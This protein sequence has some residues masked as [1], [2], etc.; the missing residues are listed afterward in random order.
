[1]EINKIFILGKLT[2]DV[3]IRP[4]GSSQ[5]GVLNLLIEAYR[6]NK[7][8]DPF[9]E[10]CYIDVDTWGNAALKAAETLRAGD[11]I[12]VTG[13]LKSSSWQDKK[14][15]ETRTKHTIYCENYE[16]QDPTQL[17]DAFP[18]QQQPITIQANQPTV[19][20]RPNSVPANAQNPVNRPVT[21]PNIQRPVVTQPQVAQQRVAPQPVRQ[22]A[23]V[24]PPE[25]EESEYGE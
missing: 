13:R 15:G 7:A 23:Y 6:D 22:H 25:L 17:S 16:L 8:G 21:Q 5:V 18:R 20:Q 11:Y 9:T 10:K 4:V 19:N 14:T 1:M 3:T 24:N 12:L 2:K